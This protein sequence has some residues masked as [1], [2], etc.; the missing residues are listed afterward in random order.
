MTGWGF[1]QQWKENI[2][3]LWNELQEQTIYRLASEVE[4]TCMIAMDIVDIDKETRIT[5]CNHAKCQMEQRR[6]QPAY[7]LMDYPLSLALEPSPTES[8]VGCD[9][10]M[11]RLKANALNPFHF[12]RL[13]KSLS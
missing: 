8:P 9:H 3:R 10:A 5:E 2:V 1:V 12:L 11:V 6:C 7:S 13:M 4:E